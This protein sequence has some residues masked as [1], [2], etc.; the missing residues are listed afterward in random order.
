MM[1][2]Y[3]VRL[4]S[5]EPPGK[6]ARLRQTDIVPIAV[7]DWL[8]TVMTTFGLELAGSAIFGATSD[9]VAP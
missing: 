2:I 1:S 5:P 3:A 9:K 6:W 4:W 7:L 8:G